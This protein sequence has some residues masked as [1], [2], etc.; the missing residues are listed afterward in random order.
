MIVS[1]GRSSLPCQGE[2][3]GRGTNG[4]KKKYRRCS[5]HTPRYVFFFSRSWWAAN[6]LCGSSDRRREYPRLRLPSVE[7]VC[8]GTFCLQV[9]PYG[10]RTTWMNPEPKKCKLEVRRTFITGDGRT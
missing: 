6:T 8:D 10:E 1:S 9:T 7:I 4:E 2:T 3:I 5:R